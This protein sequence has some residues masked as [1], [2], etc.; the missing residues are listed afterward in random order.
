M[1]VVGAMNLDRMA[2]STFGSSI[3]YQVSQQEFKMQC[4]VER[5]HRL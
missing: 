5:I 4:V 2:E 3:K 1:G